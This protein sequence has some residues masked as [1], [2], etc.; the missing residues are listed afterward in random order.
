MTVF[1]PVYLIMAIL[2]MATVTFIIRALPALIPKV[3]LDTPWLHRLN[4]YLPLCVLILLILTSLQLPIDTSATTDDATATANNQ[5]LLA[6]LIALTG[7]LLSYHY[8]RQLF[9]SMVVGIAILN[10]CL[11]LFTTTSVP[12]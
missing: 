2:A 6:Q 11:W 7:V 4:S 5:L 8:F 9:V 12:F 1:S 10:A 3:Y